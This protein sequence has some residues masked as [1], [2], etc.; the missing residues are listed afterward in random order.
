MPSNNILAGG[1]PQVTVA[2]TP[3]QRFRHLLQTRGQA[4]PA[5]MK[6]H[7][8]QLFNC[9]SSTSGARWAPRRTLG[10]FQSVRPR[11]PFMSDHTSPQQFRFV[12]AVVIAQTITA[13]DPRKIA[14]VIKCV[15]RTSHTHSIQKSANARSTNSAVH[16]AK[17]HRRSSWRTCRTMSSMRSP[18][19]I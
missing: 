16:T 9:P 6:R 19:A 17:E 3:Q 10:A 1:R 2:A 11:P 5:A 7:L 8:L 12:V 13:L 18:S 4:N 15:P 14:H